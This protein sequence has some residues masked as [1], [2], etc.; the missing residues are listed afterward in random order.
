MLVALACFAVVAWTVAPATSHLPKIMDTLLDHAEMIESHGHT[1][2]FEDD[3]MWALHGHSHDVAD[4]D[5]TQAVVLPSE[6]ARILPKIKTAKSGLIRIH[7]STP[8]F[9]LERPPRA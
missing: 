3:L 5:H 1:H 8:L 2:G 9:L 7:W 6:T 4:H